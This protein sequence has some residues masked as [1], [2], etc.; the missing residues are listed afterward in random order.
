MGV[1]YL[2][3][4]K[5]IRG[6]VEKPLDLGGVQVH[7]DHPVHA[8]VGYQ[9]GN[10]LRGYGHARLVLAVLAGVTVIRYNRGYSTG[11]GPTAGIDHDKQL[12]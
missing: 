9:I 7:Q 2:G 4:V 5:V 6:A 12:D 3:G 8:G 10:Q 11:G 1:E